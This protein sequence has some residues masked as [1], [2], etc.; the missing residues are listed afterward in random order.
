MAIVP[1]DA[2]PCINIHPEEIVQALCKLMCSYRL[3]KLTLHFH[4]LHTC[5]G[6]TAYLIE[7]HQAAIREV[8]PLVGDGQF[9]IHGLPCSSVS[10][11]GLL[12]HAEVVTPE[13]IMEEA[14]LPVATLGIHNTKNHAIHNSSHRLQCHPNFRKNDLWWCELLT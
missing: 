13:E 14:I 10:V 4:T 3:H 8:K 7:P 6:V 11:T 12:Q 5:T 2:F 1:S 9:R